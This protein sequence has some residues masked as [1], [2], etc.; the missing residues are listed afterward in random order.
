[1]WSSAT[2]GQPD[3]ESVPSGTTLFKMLSKTKQ[4]HTSYFEKKTG[5]SINKFPP[6]RVMA[7]VAANPFDLCKTIKE[8]KR[9]KVEERVNEEVE[10]EE[11]G[12][13]G[14]DDE[15]VVV[16]VFKEGDVG[17]VVERM[18]ESVVKKTWMR[19]NSRLKM[20]MKLFTVLLCFG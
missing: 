12:V 6:N 13:E 16:A 15:G 19:C 11:S 10:S 20:H 3:G 8:K 9:K 1:M 7:G 2:F 17:L 5:Y 18:I 4:T 14:G